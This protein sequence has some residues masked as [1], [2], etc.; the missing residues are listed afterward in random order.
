MNDLQVQLKISLSEQLN[1]L[2]K[3]K[4]IRFGVPLTQFVKHLILK[5]VE[6][7]DYPTFEASRR[8]TQKAK[9][10]LAE[11]DKAIV[12]DNIHKYFKKL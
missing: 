6:K 2:L 4:A 12:I 1:D 11:E 8:T 9:K 5:E 10:A 3:S 7:E